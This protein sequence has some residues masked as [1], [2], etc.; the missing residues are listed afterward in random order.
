MKEIKLLF[1]LLW[2]KLKVILSIFHNSV[3]IMMQNY[4]KKH[5]RPVDKQ[6][7]TANSG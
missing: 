7:W 3:V 6:L 2:E 1:M 4:G 5:H